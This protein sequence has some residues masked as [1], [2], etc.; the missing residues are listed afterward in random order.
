MHNGDADEIAKLIEP[1]RAHGRVY[2]DPDLFELERERIF[3]RVWL[4]DSMA[5]PI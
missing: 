4:F 5:A 3:G 1:G 2:T